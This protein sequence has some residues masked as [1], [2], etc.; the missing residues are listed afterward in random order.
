MEAKVIPL[1]ESKFV[2]RDITEIVQEIKK[3]KEGVYIATGSIFI[4]GA[5]KQLFQK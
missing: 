2:Y 4:A 3:D 5:V 1:L